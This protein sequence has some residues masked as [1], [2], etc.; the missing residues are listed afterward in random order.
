MSETFNGWANSW[1]TIKTVFPAMVAYHN[2]FC[3]PGITNQGWRKTKSTYYILL[4]Q[5]NEIA[6]NTFAKGHKLLPIQAIIL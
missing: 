3:K 6:S 4:V 5:H 2:N 1:Q